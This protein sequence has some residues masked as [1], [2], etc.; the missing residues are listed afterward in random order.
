M[1][2]HSDYI[3]SALKQH[4]EAELRKRLVA[5]AMGTDNPHGSPPWPLATEYPSPAQMVQAFPGAAGPAAALTAATH[6]SPGSSPMGVAS[7]GE[8]RTRARYQGGRKA[9]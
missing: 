1:H 3:R 7:N 4:A 5:Q 9:E 8:V 6:A 2:V